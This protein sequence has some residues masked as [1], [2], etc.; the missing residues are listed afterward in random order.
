MNCNDLHSTSRFP[1]Q[2]RE[3]FASKLLGQTQRLA[4]EV[5]SSFRLGGAAQDEIQDAVGR[6]IKAAQIAILKRSP[7]LHAFSALPPTC[8]ETIV[9][10]LPLHDRISF[11]HTCRELRHSMLRNPALWHN[12]CVAP[13]LEFKGNIVISADE[14]DQSI[15]PPAAW[16]AVEAMIQRARPAPPS[17]FWIFEVLESR[18]CRSMMRAIIQS[19]LAQSK[20]LR[21]EP[22]GKHMLDF[23][24]DNDGQWIMGSLSRAQFALIED[25]LCSPA[26]QLETLQLSFWYDQYN[27]TRPRHTLS[28]D[29]LR[30]Q[31]GVLRYCLIEGV[32]LMPVVYPAFSQLSVL[33]YGVSYRWILTGHLVG[34][35][36]SMP[37]LEYL[38]LDCI[39]IEDTDTFPSTI[40]HPSLRGVSV[41]MQEGVVRP[42][43]TPE[44]VWRGICV[45]LDALGRFAPHIRTFVQFRE[46][47]AS[48]LPWPLHRWND[49]SPS[50]QVPEEVHLLGDM[51]WA[52][53]ARPGVNLT[54]VLSTYIYNIGP[55]TVIDF[56][57]ENAL[58]YV[59]TMTLADHLWSEAPPPDAPH[60][61]NLTIIFTGGLQF[62]GATHPF[63]SHWD[64]AWHMSSLKE[65]AFVS[66]SLPSSTPHPSCT[67]ISLND[68]ADFVTTQ[69]NFDEQLDRVGIHGFTTLHCGH[70]QD[71]LADALDQLRLLAKHVNLDANIPES[72]A[73]IIALHSLHYKGLGDEARW[74]P[75][76]IFTEVVQADQVDWNCL[77][78]DP[79]PTHMDKF[80]D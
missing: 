58:H 79:S 66:Q 1:E 16:H 78:A 68:I 2:A 39:G 45:S 9:S 10:A 20:L 4:S 50:L 19:A 6:H 44:D 14:T 48:H 70:R 3:S 27:Q 75:T 65:I 13:E 64:P 46:V 73:R 57:A 60:L 11:S 22:F 76:K 74:T 24:D 38:G 77:G 12:I 18:L 42:G 23:G 33:D 49:L 17:L 35:L 53:Y 62:W 7:L 31:P 41:R 36:H 5:S 34:M 54:L 80:I 51:F 67:T 40:D 43:E 29:I 32:E 47:Y 25:A 28:T 72:T 8:L 56:L 26:P 61:R 59:T 30:G 55:S 21:L 52:M 63:V 69:L 15:E 71:D 37:L